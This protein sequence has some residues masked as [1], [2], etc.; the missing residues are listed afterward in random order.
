M[1]TGILTIHGIATSARF[2]E[3]AEEADKVSI[4]LRQAVAVG[5]S[6]PLI[7][8]QI[9]D[10]LR[11]SLERSGFRQPD[12]LPTGEYL[13]PRKRG[14]AVVVAAGIMV[15]ADEY[16]QRYNGIDLEGFRHRM[17]PELFKAF[18]R[19]IGSIPGHPDLDISAVTTIPE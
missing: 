15:W 18:V 7:W 9:D 1:S 13:P 11:S 4:K 8:R 3:V 17:S 14:G 10:I 12:R 5:D 6:E 2:S 16:E 19:H